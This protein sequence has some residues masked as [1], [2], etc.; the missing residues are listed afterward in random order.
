MPAKLLRP[1]G[2]AVLAI[3]LVRLR[4]H[5]QFSQQ[6]PR[7]L[8]HPRRLLQVGFK[9]RSLA[10]GEIE[11]AAYPLDQ[12]V[13]QVV[14]LHDGR[15]RSGQIRLRPI[16]TDAPWNSGIPAQPAPRSTLRSLRLVP[17]RRYT[18]GIARYLFAHNA[19]L[20]RR[21]PPGGAVH[22]SRSIDRL[23]SNFA[24]S[25]RF[26]ARLRR[27]ECRSAP[28]SGRRARCVCPRPN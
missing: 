2:S 16:Q 15:M 18:L 28:G 10:S 19:S 4:P 17:A 21:Q 12:P 11:E 5:A 3:P 26:A 9:L 22:C 23:R 6:I 13:V 14:I 1:G 20:C 8:N 27:A 7:A 24:T 25:C